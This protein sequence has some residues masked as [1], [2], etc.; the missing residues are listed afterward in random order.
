[1]AII[2]IEGFEMGKPAS[3]LST[4]NF[5]GISTGAGLSIQ[6]TVVRTGNYA[7]GVNGSGSGYL[8]SYVVPA[9]GET[10]TAATP[11][12]W[13]RFYFRYDS[14]S[15]QTGIARMFVSAGGHNVMLLNTDGTLQLSCSGTGF[16]SAASATA[17][18]VGQWYCLEW[19]FFL[20]DSAAYELRIDGVVE[21]TGTAD[22]KVAAGDTS[23]L[24]LD[25]GVVSGG[26]LTAYFDDLAIDNAD[27]PGPGRIIR[28]VPTGNG[29][30]TGW[31]AG[32]G[33]GDFNEWDEVPHDT[34]TTTVT[35]S[36]NTTKES[37]TSSNVMP[38]SASIT[39]VMACAL[40]K[41]AAQTCNWSVG[42]RSGSTDSFSTA[43]DNGSTG[44][45][46]RRKINTTDPSTSAAWTRAGVVAAEVAVNHAQ[47]QSRALTLTAMSLMVQYVDWIKPLATNVNQS[48]NRAANF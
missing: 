28:R 11:P 1:M 26:S 29:N 37:G 48:R 2:L 44:Y 32:T 21:I 20:A 42:I 14:I 43:A 35:T 34:D 4:E 9:T 5:W 30:Y 10:G 19:K 25:L 13:A 45:Y 38:H 23:V 12:I 8:Y 31:V 41:D 27:Y 47:G 33:S 15:G 7:L 3:N 22:T 24:A 40:V 6:S 46:Q 17:L 36:T 16:T 18:E 39:A